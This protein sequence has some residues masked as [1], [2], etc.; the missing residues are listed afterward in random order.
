MKEFELLEPFP[1]P[2]PEDFLVNEI[3]FAI[4]DA[5]DKNVKDTMNFYSLLGISFIEILCGF[6]FVLYRYAHHSHAGDNKFGRTKIARISVTLGMYMWVIAILWVPVD[7]I[8][9]TKGSLTRSINYYALKSF[10]TF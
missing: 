10:E 7:C 4:E 3:N 8:L 5:N 6:I 9:S 1:E 2:E